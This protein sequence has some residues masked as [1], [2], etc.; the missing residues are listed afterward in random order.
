MNGI[1]NR[2][3]VNLLTKKNK[4]DKINHVS[5]NLQYQSKSMKKELII[6]ERF[7]NGN[8]YSLRICVTFILLHRFF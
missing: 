4:Y 6:K 7:Y 2:D 3:M 8:K 5:E 1:L